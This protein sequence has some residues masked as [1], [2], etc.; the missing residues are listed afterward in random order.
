M[1]DMRWPILFCACLICIISGTARGQN[2]EIRFHNLGIREGLSHSLVYSMAE[3]SLGFLWF[4]TQDGLD[5]YDGYEFKTYFK[6]SGNRHPSDS[7]VQDLYIDSH[8]QLWI[9]YQGSGFERFDPH[10]ETFY[11]YRPDSLDP[12]SI[13]S[14]T[15]PSGQ[16]L[17]YSVFYEDREGTLWIGTNRGLNRYD[18]GKDIFHSIRHDPDDPGSLSDDRIISITGDGEGNLWI[19]TYH[20]LNRFNPSTGKID[21]LDCSTEPGGILKDSIITCLFVDNDHTVWAGTIFSGLHIIE[22]IF[23]DSMKVTRLL[24]EPLNPNHVPGI[25][26]IVRTSPGDMLVGSNHGLYRVTKSE[27]S[28]SAA[29]FEETRNIK[30]F[31]I[32][33]DM[34]GYVWAGSDA[35]V[36]RGLFRVHPDLQTVETFIGD[37]QSPYAFNGKKLQFIHQSRTG[38]LWIGSEKDGVYRVDLNA[39]KFKS[40]DHYPERG[41]YISD[42]EVYSIYENEERELYIGTKTELNM[43]D[44]KNGSWKGFGNEY[45]LKKDL[46]YEYSKQLPAKLIGVIKEAPDGKLWLGPFDYKVSLYDPL[47]ELFLCF[48]QNEG[49]PA[50]FRAWSLRSICVTLDGHVYFGAT[51]AGLCRLKSDGYSFEY[52]PVVQTGN[53]HGTNDVHIQYIYEDSDSILWM[54]TFNGGLNRFDPRT[55]RFRHFVHDPSDPASLSNNRV[56]C[57]LE[58]E[59]YGEDILWI[60]TNNGGLN[61]FDKRAETF[62]AYTMREGMPSNAVHGILEDRVGNLW[63]STNRGLVQ[64]DPVT[65]EINI[66]TTEDGLVGN[67][68]NEGAFFKNREGVMYFGGTNGV[69]YFLPEEIRENP[70]YDAPVVL[71][72]F[73]LSG[74]SVLPGDTVNGRVVLE[75]SIQYTDEIR[76][77]HRDR[78]LSF[79]FASLDFIAPNKL[80][81]RYMLEGFEDDW[82]EVN[83]GQRIISYTNIPSGNYTLKILGTNSDGVWSRSPTLITIEMIPPFWETFWFKLVIVAF[84]LLIL[85]S[86]IQ[87]RTRLLKNQKR[88][89]EQ[90]VEERTRD[91]KE[92]NRLLE[93]KQ[94]EI[95]KQSEKI[96]HQR[97]NLSEQNKVLE[98]QKSE[99]QLMAERLHE[100]DQ[101]KLRFFTNISHEFR[102]PLTLIMGPTEKLMQ[103][104]NYGDAPKIKRELDLIYRNERRLFRLIN[105]LLEIRRVETGN[106]KLEVSRDDLI[107]YLK[108]IYELFLPYAEKKEVDFRF[109]TDLPE[110]II[111]FDT[112]KIEKV[113]YNLLSNAF[114]YTPKRGRVLMHIG[115]TTRNGREMVGISV[116]DT[117]PGITPEVL[118]HIFDRFFQI[119]NRHRSGKISSGIGLSLSRDLIEKHCGEIEVTSDGKSGTSFMVYL[120]LKEDCYKPEEIM[121][122]SGGNV[123]MEYINSMI[124]TYDYYLNDQYDAPLVGEDL[125]RILVVEDNLDMQKYLYNELTESY[126]VLLAQNGREAME[127]S[128]GNGR[129]RILQTA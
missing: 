29:L 72:S 26:T 27:G 104:K 39:K 49:D 110:L 92:A 43:I 105:Q 63:L 79:E 97:D 14:N 8:D 106:L 22:H 102:T 28:Y 66:Y 115:K 61:K 70:Y 69:T 64:F 45:N 4:G 17:R 20:G 30:I 51:E 99:I 24:E 3:D 41:L 23:S 74:T 95:V 33:E 127:I 90:E 96:A 38:L 19:A 112:D 121:G 129:A 15:Y 88:M 35:N 122:E 84:I 119:T 36:R 54:G 126:N 123:S 114:K 125:F 32:L 37:V 109:R 6:G 108:S 62:T 47:R 55:G 120:P 71:T 56:K 116:T 50:S 12:G 107:A 10:T 101:M 76:L 89:L 118:P 2:P 82:N 31:H 57:I 73:R 68:F 25:Y 94:E 40:I 124:E 44:L 46:T 42:D 87:V 18:R 78:F 34:H 81:Y 91:L 9:W 13:S 60:G 85:L 111:Y 5:R 77:T 86:I 65:E 53:S 98:D 128:R 113:F 67:E 80:K 75:K 16:T 103:Y 59:I 7:W 100:S 21:R 1:Q 58:P 93:L 83:A 52:F 117:G 48:H 11:P